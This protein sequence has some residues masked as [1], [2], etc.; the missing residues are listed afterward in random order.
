MT[1]RW[2][3]IGNSNVASNIVRRPV[4]TPQ[5]LAG[6]GT[7]GPLLARIYAAREVCT[8]EEVDH[9]LPRLQPFHGLLGLDVA[10]D[11]L[12]SAIAADER[13]LIVG[14]F[15]AD[16]A[17]STAVAV[18]AL[19]ALG[20]N[21]VDYLVP[22]RFTFGYGLTP[23]IVDVAAERNPH[24]IVTVDNGISSHEGVER[25][26]AFGIRVVIT[27]HHLPP[28][29]LPNAEAIVNPNQ[30]GDNSSLG[31]MAGVGVIFYVML[32]LRSRL[33]EQGHFGAGTGPNLGVLLDLV[34]LGTVADVAVLDRNNRVLVAQGLAR[35]HRGQGQPGVRALLEVAQRDP[36]R[37]SAS[38]LGFAAGP[39]LNAA[40]RLNDMGLGI[41]CLLS[42]DPKRASEWAEQLDA[43]NRERR[44]LEGEMTEEARAQ[45]SAL[46]LGDEGKLPRGLCLFDERWHP[47]I[48]GIIA[49][50]VKDDCHRP[51]IAFA[52]DDSGQLKG[53]G[54]SV[55][56]VHIRDAI[57]AVASSHPQWVERFGGH[58]MAAG[59][60]IAGDSF[61]AFSLA[62]DEVVRAR[63]PAEAL[64]GTLFS[65]GELSA[66]DLQLEVAEQLRDAGPWGQGFPEPL[67]DGMFVVNEHRIVGTNHTKLTLNVPGSP[68][69]IDGIAFNIVEPDLAVGVEVHIAYR[70]DVNHFRGR[71]RLQLI[72]EHLQVAR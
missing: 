24:L 60:T 26:K 28:E 42:D 21:H 45:V 62:F 59:L 63:L 22:N 44:S 68:I 58:A 70:L 71:S 46:E 34:A 38:D 72:I 55:S 9:T 16:G 15:D 66:N 64:V 37:A 36:A 57:E 51:V 25:A 1:A 67:F 27:D 39:R 48:V 56:G 12:Q 31:S 10:V 29:T 6:L 7:V 65:D 35:L 54:R 8:L 32:A 18:R 43:L 52:R 53:S 47:G 33:R 49:S 61:E 4:P 13:I 69:V 50:R 17:T 5:A 3:R 30:R 40:G 2:V 19:R 11:L 41:E 14:D 20:A 23:E